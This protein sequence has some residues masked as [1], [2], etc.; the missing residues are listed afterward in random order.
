MFLFVRESAARH[1]VT[2]KMSRVLDV[3]LSFLAIM[4]SLV[5]LILFSLSFGVMEINASFN[6]RLAIMAPAISDKE[7]K[8]WR[9]QWAKMRGQRDYQALV[10]AMEKRAADLHIQLP[11]LR[12]P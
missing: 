8:E 5:V 1:E 6:Q 7:Y 3:A 12:K 2:R 4:L 9:A 11:E 10:S